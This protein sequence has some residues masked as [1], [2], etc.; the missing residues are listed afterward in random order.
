M[1][2][3]ET[4]MSHRER[5]EA[6]ASDNGKWP[7]AIERSGEGYRIMQTQCDWMAW[8]AACPEGLEAV[9]AKAIRQA[10]EHWA[11]YEPSICAAPEY[12]DILI[13]LS[14]APKPGDV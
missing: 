7:E 10:L 3:N 8:Q 5:F 4:V 13:A 14:A 2:Q 1:S 11:E 9:D 12:T 6:W